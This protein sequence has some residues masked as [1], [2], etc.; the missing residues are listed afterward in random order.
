MDYMLDGYAKDDWS[1]SF[2]YLGNCIYKIFMGYNGCIFLID[3]LLNV[4]YFISA[5][6]M[7]HRVIVRI[8][9]LCGK[10]LEVTFKP[11]KDFIMAIIKRL[12]STCMM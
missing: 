11:G 7:I 8:Q 5:K 4:L 1:F 12:S 6:F 10:F 3:Y 2:I 9:G